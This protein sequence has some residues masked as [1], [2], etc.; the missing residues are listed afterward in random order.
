MQVY[1]DFFLLFLC[2][3]FCLSIL[4]FVSSRKHL[5]LTLL[6]LEFMVLVVFLTLCLFLSC[7]INEL[8][9]LLIFLTFTVCEGA[10]GLGIL[11]SM[12]RCHGNDNIQSLSFLLW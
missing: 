5:L 12:I 3:M 8:Y 6:S 9:F 7:F 2:F 10:V 1:V 4:V 11:V